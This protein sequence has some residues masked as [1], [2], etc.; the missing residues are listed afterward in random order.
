MLVINLAGSRFTLETVSDMSMRDFLGWVKWSGIIFPEW[1]QHHSMGTG[2]ELKIKSRERRSWE[3]VPNSFCTLAANTLWPAASYSTVTTHS[4]N[5]RLCSQTVS[6]NKCPAFL[7]VLL[8]KCFVM[9]RRKY[10]EDY[11]SRMKRK[12]STLFTTNYF[13]QGW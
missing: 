10:L 11:L 5:H 1:R 4:Q 8:L 7:K 9:A 3:P 6:Q 12:L 13:P 2:P